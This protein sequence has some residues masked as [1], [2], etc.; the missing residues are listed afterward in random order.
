MPKPNYSPEFKRKAVE[1][2]LNGGKSAAA[3]CRE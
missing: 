1:E 2:H 3:I